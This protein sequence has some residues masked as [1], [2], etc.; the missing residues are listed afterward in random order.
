MA[1][2]KDSCVF[3]GYSITSKGYKV[4]NKMTRLIVES[5]HINFDEIKE[6]SKALDY[7]N[8]DPAPT[9][10]TTSNHNRS[11]LSTHDHSNEPSNSELVPNVSPQADTTDSSQQELDFLFSPLYNEFFSASNTSVSKSSS[12]SDNSQQQDTP[13][14]TNVQ[15]T[16]ESITPTTIVHAEENNNDQAEDV[17]FEPYQFI[18]PLCIP[19]QE[20]PES[21]SRNVDTSNMYT[22]YQRVTSRILRSILIST[23]FLF[24][25]LN[26][27]LCFTR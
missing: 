25:L 10:Q 8:S 18:N 19:V 12:L 24:L 3:V 15:P 13:P 6:F 16:T 21:S 20:V 9:L 1:E 23:L 11:E 27:I 26:K 2:K 17:Q 14:T 5:I 7:D 22:F 4:Y